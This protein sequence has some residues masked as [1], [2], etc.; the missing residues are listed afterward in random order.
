MAFRGGLAGIHV[1]FVVGAAVADAEVV[2]PVEAVIVAEAAEE[3][4]AVDDVG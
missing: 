2:V 3:A 4:E 1:E